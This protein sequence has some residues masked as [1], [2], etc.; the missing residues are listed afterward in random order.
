LPVFTSV[1]RE[2]LEPVARAA[3]DLRLGVG[4]FAAHEGDERALFVVLAGRIGVTQLVDGIRRTIGAR[5]PGQSFGESPI[6]VGVPFQGSFHAREPSRVMRLD[7]AQFH[8]L[9]AAAPQVLTDVAAQA[10]DRIGGLQGIATSPAKARATL[11]GHRWDAGCHALRTFLTRN[12]IT[13]D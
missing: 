1:A 11:I 13:F 8:A 2:T 10:R 5:A 7:A 12:Q 3:A 6:I 4:E 9:A